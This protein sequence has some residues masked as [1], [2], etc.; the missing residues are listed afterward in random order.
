[1]NG[2]GWQ[3]GVLSISIVLDEALERASD[4]Q[5]SNAGLHPERYSPALANSLRERLARAVDSMPTSQGPKTPHA[6]R[7]VVFK[8]RIKRAPQSKATPDHSHPAASLRDWRDPQ[9]ITDL[10]VS[11]IDRVEVVRNIRACLT[12]G[13]YDRRCG[14][15]SWG[16]RRIRAAPNPSRTRVKIS[17]PISQLATTFSAAW[18]NVS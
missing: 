12:K 15:I 5:V 1:M 16:T 7:R 9:V 14:N 13:P 4:I 11:T 18:P 3:D 10:N 8:G 2:K 17:T 6:I